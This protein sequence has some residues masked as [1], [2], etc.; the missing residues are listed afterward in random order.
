MVKHEEER[1]Q[2]GGMGSGDLSSAAKQAMPKHTLSP[3]SSVLIPALC[4]GL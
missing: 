4:A 2:T 1:K 3:H